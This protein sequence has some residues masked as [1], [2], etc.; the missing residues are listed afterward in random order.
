[1]KARLVSAKRILVFVLVVVCGV[2]AVSRMRSCRSNSRGDLQFV[3]GDR[4]KQG[5]MQT[6]LVVATLRR[7]V[8]TGRKI[9]RLR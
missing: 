4:T 3:M 5:S 9:W 8:V 2:G 1:M 7:A 6:G